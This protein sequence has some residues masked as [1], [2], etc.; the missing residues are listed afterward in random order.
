MV[1]HT[2]AGRHARTA[3]GLRAVPH[4]PSSLLP[5]SCL[6]FTFHLPCVA[7]RLPGHALCN[8]YNTASEAPARMQ[9]GLCLT[10]ALRGQWWRPRHLCA[11]CK[12]GPLWGEQ[13]NTALQTLAGQPSSHTHK[14]TTIRIGT[15]N[16]KQY[17]RPQATVRRATARARCW[18]TTASTTPRTPRASTRCARPRLPTTLGLMSIHVRPPYTWRERK[19]ALSPSKAVLALLPC[20]YGHR[21]DHVPQ[22]QP[23]ELQLRAPAT[24]ATPPRRT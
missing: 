6:S 7:L 2:H 4:P 1:Q 16:K 3:A 5:C 24:L 14:S 23:S 8:H 13:P 12:H 11:A 20:I 22:P 18:R 10:Q 17:S 19:T 9:M 15:N 21:D